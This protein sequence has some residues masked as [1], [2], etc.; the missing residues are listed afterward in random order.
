MGALH[1]GLGWFFCGKQPAAENTR[2]NCRAERFPKVVKAHNGNCQSNR[3]VVAAGYLLYRV[4][5]GLRQF[6]Y[7]MINNLYQLIKIM[8]NLLLYFTSYAIIQMNFEE[9][10][11]EKITYNL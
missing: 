9:G 11:Y 1:L 4:Q 8:L 6:L 7:K 5:Y 10:Y 3:N 2:E